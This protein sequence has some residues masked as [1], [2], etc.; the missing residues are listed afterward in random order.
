[1]ERPAVDLDDDLRR[2][3]RHVNPVRGDWVIGL[4]TRNSRFA[5]ELDEQALGL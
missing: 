1:M 5:Q 3:E 4:P 2:W